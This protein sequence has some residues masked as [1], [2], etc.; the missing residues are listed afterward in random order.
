MLKSAAELVDPVEYCELIEL[1]CYVWKRE[2]EGAGAVA[3]AP[4]TQ[5]LYI[6]KYMIYNL[7]TGQLSAVFRHPPSWE[8]NLQ[9]TSI[10]VRASWQLAIVECVGS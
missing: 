10:L 5:Y 3:P 8:M 6:E 4:Q 9:L 1:D 2:K 7:L